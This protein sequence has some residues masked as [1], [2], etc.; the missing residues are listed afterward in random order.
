MKGKNRIYY[1]IGGIALFGLFYFLLNRQG[2]APS[3]NAQQSGNIVINGPSDAEL[4]LQSQIASASIQAGIARNDTNAQVAI[5]TQENQALIALSTI[6]QSTDLA[7]LDI[8]NNLGIASL[9]L[10]RDIF[11][12]QSQNEII[13]SQLNAD[14]ALAQINTNADIVKTQLQTNADIF[15]TQVKAAQFGQ[16]VNQVGSLKKSDRDN[17]LRHLTTGFNGD[18]FRFNGP[19]DSVNSNIGRVNLNLIR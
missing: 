5:A 17:A 14:I 7:A 12:Q 10:E 3:N 16:L 4:A 1:I 15:N 8:Q 6:Q 9:N 2:A 18:S 11:A 13:N 19:N